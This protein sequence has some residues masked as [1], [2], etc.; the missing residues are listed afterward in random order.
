MFSFFHF[1]FS[2]AQAVNSGKFQKFDYGSAAANQL[3]YGQTTPPLYPLHSLLHPPLA[4]FA[5]GQDWLADPT[6]FQNLLKSLPAQNQPI[7]VQQNVTCRE[8]SWKILF[9]FFFF[10]L[11]ITIWILFGEKMHIQKFMQKLLNWLNNMLPK[12]ENKLFF[13]NKST[14]LFLFF[15][16]NNIHHD[17]SLAIILFRGQIRLITIIFVILD[18]ACD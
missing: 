13:L 10:R 14:I 3:H 15:F 5:G 1:F 11:D 16:T 6:D 18:I 4:F 9:V 7:Y 2:Q 17:S 12:I 8:N